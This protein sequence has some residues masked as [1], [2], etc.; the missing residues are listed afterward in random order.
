MPNARLRL[1]VR[2]AAR[3]PMATDSGIL[4]MVMPQDSASVEFD[5]VAAAQS[6]IAQPS[7]RLC[8]QATISRGHPSVIVR[9]YEP[10]EPGLWVCAPAAQKD[11]KSTR[12]NSSHT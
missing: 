7:K 10:V 2:L 5:P 1:E 3:S 4:W 12:L 11:R 8:R 6:P 9:S